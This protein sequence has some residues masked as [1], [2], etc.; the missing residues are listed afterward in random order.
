M[1][2]KAMILGRVG[3][4][5]FK[6]TKKGDWVCKLSIA[7]NEKYTD[8]KG[9]KHDD[10][11]WHHVNFFNRFAEI[12]NKFAHVGD[13]IYIEGKISNFQ[14]EENGV[15]R[16]IS[17]IIGSEIRLLPNLKKDK[18]QEVDENKLDHFVSIDSLDV[19]KEDDIPF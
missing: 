14:T 1:I 8:K 7:T 16:T 19:N 15:K 4:K 12:A 17:T 3:K 5:D 11:N 18:V 9:V 6:E 13:L 10:T 2:N